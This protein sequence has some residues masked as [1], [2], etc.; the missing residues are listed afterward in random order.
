MYINKV[1]LSLL[2][3]GSMGILTTALQV[4]YYTDLFCK[5]KFFLGNFTSPPCGAP[6]QNTNSWLIVCDPG[7]PTCEALDFY[8]GDT[9]E[10]CSESPVKQ[11]GCEG[12]GSGDRVCV[13]REDLGGA[14]APVLWQTIPP[15]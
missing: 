6:P 13:S 10:T 4:N 12:C 1:M 9:I 15:G 5:E 8:L 3:A 14:K 7:S 11:L 2:G